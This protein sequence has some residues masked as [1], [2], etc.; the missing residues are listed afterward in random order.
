MA[1]LT[2]ETRAATLSVRA[3]ARKALNVSGIEL[4]KAQQKHLASVISWCDGQLKTA[5][6]KQAA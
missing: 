4:P 5:T 1:T 6:A 2:K 3:K